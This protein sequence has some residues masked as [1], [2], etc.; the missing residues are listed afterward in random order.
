MC[1]SISKEKKQMMRDTTKKLKDK[2]AEGV[3]PQVVKD[4]FEAAS[5]K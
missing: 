5:N 1:V 2:K 4:R 3:V